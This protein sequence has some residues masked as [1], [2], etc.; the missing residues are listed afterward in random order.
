MAV[1]ADSGEPAIFIQRTG[2]D[3][4]QAKIRVTAFRRELI[5]HKRNKRRGQTVNRI[6]RTYAQIIGPLHDRD[7]LIS[8]VL[9][10]IETQP[11]ESQDLWLDALVEKM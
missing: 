7:A 3:R 5:T 2:E 9:A 8:E 4:W 1:I 11:R 10:W 6:D